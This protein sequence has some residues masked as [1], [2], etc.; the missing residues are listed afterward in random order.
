MNT[1]KVY[2]ADSGAVANLKKDFPLFQGQ[3]NNKTL[4]VF[5]PTSALL[6]NFKVV[7]STESQNDITGFIGGVAVQIGAIATLP[8]GKIANS[9]YYFMRYLQVV[10][11]D[12]KEYALFERFLPSAFTTFFGITK[13]IINVVEGSATIE[14]DQIVRN[15]GKTIVS[16]KVDLIVEQSSNLD[17]EPPQENALEDIATQITLLAQNLENK[18]D[19]VDSRLNAPLSVSAENRTVVGAINDI[20]NRVDLNTTQIGN[21]TLSIEQVE[22]EITRLSSIVGTGEDFITTITSS[23]EPT[24]AILSNAVVQEKGRQPKGGDTIIYVQELENETDKTFKFIFNGTGWIGYEIPPLEKASNSNY[25]II[26][27][28]VD[29][30][31]VMRVSIGNGQIN[32]ITILSEYGTYV[33]I[34][35][36]ITSTN[37]RLSQVLNGQLAVGLS[38]RAIADQNGNNIADTYMTQTNGATK[39]FVQDYALPK[40]FNEVKY[41]TPNGYSDTIDTSASYVATKTSSNIGYTELFSA[42]NVLENVKFQLASK[43][44]YSNTFYIATTFG[45]GI[46]QFQFRLST[47]IGISGQGDILA[48]VENSSVIDMTSG[49]ISKVQFGDRLN[50]L[51][52]S[53]L[54]LVSGDYIRQELEI[55]TFDSATTE[56]TIYS[57]ETT[58]SS[59]YLYTNSYVLTLSQGKLGELSSVNCE[60]A[61]L[62]GTNVEIELPTGQLFTNNTLY[63]FALPTLID[64][65]ND[66]PIYLVN[67]LSEQIPIITPYDFANSTATIKEIEQLAITNGNDEIIESYA[68]IGYVTNI[69]DIVK[70]YPIMDNL[71]SYASKDYVVETANSYI[72]R[73]QKLGFDA[74][75]SGNIVTATLDTSI[76]DFDLV[77]NTGYLFNIHLPLV[78]NIEPSAKLVL[79]DKN[80]N[81]ININSVFNKDITDSITIGDLY[82]VQEYNTEIGYTWE[83]YG[84]YAEVSNN[85]NVQRVIYTDTIVD[86]APIRYN[87]DIETTSWQSYSSPSS[88]F[89]YIASVTLPVSY[90]EDLYDIELVNNNSEIFATFGIAGGTYDSTTKIVTIL[91]VNKPIATTTITLKVVRL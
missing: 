36:Y 88:P 12:N 90:N 54:S 87:F 68:F 14:N 83:F 50:N 82:Q 4:Q 1:I 69:N 67:D 86:T 89:N 18:Q 9:E 46:K 41:L 74:T 25:G 30:P 60:V 45:G 63:R 51:G 33:G 77:A 22:Q 13:M 7:S 56:I 40:T 55:F 70:V 44:S 65:D 24:Q 84:H 73:E 43:N 16:Q 11:E 6:S 19:K 28:S 64:Y 85:G 2:L 66:T 29:T 31:N 72:G 59:F 21:N 76:A 61:S 8:N 58:P 35:P 37:T 62:V 91:A 3:Y 57:T 20:N 5:V 39:S 52:E 38:S 15:I 32:E 47:Y 53:V 80:G 27:G 79:Q 17:N 34:V 81:T 10:V 75:L 48:N 26:K 71:S 78:G 23:S 49:Q 42:T